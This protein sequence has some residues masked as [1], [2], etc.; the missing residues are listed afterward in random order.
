[1]SRIFLEWRK[2]KRKLTQINRIA[3][4]RRRIHKDV[5]FFFFSAS[6]RLLSILSLFPQDEDKDEEIQEAS[7]NWKT[8]FLP[9]K[10]AAQIEFMLF[11]LISYFRYYFVFGD[12]LEV[13][14]K[15]EGTSF[16][17]MKIIKVNVIIEHTPFDLVYKIIQMDVE[18]FMCLEIRCMNDA[19]RSLGIQIGTTTSESLLG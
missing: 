12:S 11:R 5:D 6:T 4:T 10:Q 17:V 3:R 7:L 8:F 13:G 14:L 19:F 15:F 16:A 1:M 18:R 2:Q 9:R